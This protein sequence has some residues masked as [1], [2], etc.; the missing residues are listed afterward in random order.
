MF[1][2]RVTVYFHG[3]FATNSTCIGSESY[4]GLRGERQVANR[5]DRDLT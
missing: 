1:F 3:W 2:V 4:L 5:Y